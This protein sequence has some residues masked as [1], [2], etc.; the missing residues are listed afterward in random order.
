MI[1]KKHEK[2]DC[3]SLA[4]S[5]LWLAQKTRGNSQPIRL[6]TKRNRDLINGVF[7]RFIVCYD[8][9]LLSLWF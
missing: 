1:V 7:P 2:Q 5:A 8:W 9:P 4:I 3:F 6:K